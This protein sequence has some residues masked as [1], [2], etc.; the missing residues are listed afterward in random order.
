MDNKDAITDF[1]ASWSKKIEVMTCHQK[2]IQTSKKELCGAITPTGAE[3]LSISK[4]TFSPNLKKWNDAWTQLCLPRWASSQ[5]QWQPSTCGKHT[6]ITKNLTKCQFIWRAL[7]WR[8]WCCSAAE[9]PCAP[10]QALIHPSQ[11][12]LWKI[13]SW[14]S[15]RMK[16]RIRK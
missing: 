16:I 9:L 5:R 4:L 11:L 14:S 10:W 3:S 2:R 7:T 13:C 1:S 6:D 8:W 15:Q 12:D